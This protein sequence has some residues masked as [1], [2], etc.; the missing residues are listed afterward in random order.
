[1]AYLPQRTSRR[2]A[3]TGIVARESTV[4]TETS[5]EAQAVSLPNFSAYIP[6]IDATGAEAHISTTVNAVRS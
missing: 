1:M 5:F 3:M 6:V 4:L 2:S